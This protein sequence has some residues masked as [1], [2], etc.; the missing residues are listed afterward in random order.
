MA[1]P[2]A[3]QST[4]PHSPINSLRPP[5]A[6]LVAKHIA[7]RFNATFRGVSRPRR[8]RISAS[9]R[10]KQTEQSVPRDSHLHHADGL[11]IFDTPL[12]H[13][14][15]TQESLASKMCSNR[16]QR[17]GVVVKRLSNPLIPSF[18]QL[19]RCRPMVASS[20][21]VVQLTHRTSFV[22]FESLFVS[23]NASFSVSRRRRHHPSAPPCAHLAANHPICPP[24]IILSPS[25]SAVVRR[26]NPRSIAL[27]PL[28]G[29]CPRPSVEFRAI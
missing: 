7:R 11:N 16:P 6:H 26:D 27:L 10:F 19:F 3:F 21:S 2:S 13:Q 1:K 20:F 9:L 18:P 12:G 5:C 22:S 23:R 24:R 4:N 14:R 8:N 28:R 25:F 15:K 29:G 17:L